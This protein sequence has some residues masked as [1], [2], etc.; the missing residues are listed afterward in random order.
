MLP[1]YVC[2]ELN[3]VLS[4][5][6][7]RAPAREQLGI[8]GAPGRLSWGWLLA[9]CRVLLQKTNAPPAFVVKELLHLGK[10]ERESTVPFAKR[11]PHSSLCYPWKAEDIFHWL[12]PSPQPLQ[13]KSA[14]LFQ[15]ALWG[16]GTVPLTEK[17]AVDLDETFS[18]QPLYRLFLA[19]NFSCCPHGFLPVVLES[20]A[21]SCVSLVITLCVQ[22]TVSSDVS[23]ADRAKSLQTDCIKKQK[24]KEKNHPKIIN[25]LNYRCCSENKFS[26]HG[27]MFST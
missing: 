11:S 6:C 2:F 17:G 1:L 13:T 12:Q 9:W 19:V 26:L 16:A 7:V 10:T 4:C 5:D 27:F 14:R 18:L 23:C 15:P 8:S 24:Y 21:L 3:R 22:P 25:P 20:C